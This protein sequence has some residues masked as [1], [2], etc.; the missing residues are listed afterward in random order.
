MGKRVYMELTIGVEMFFIQTMVWALCV[1]VQTKRQSWVR[2]GKYVNGIAHIVEWSKVSSTL[3]QV[4]ISGHK[5]TWCV[6]GGLEWPAT[7]GWTHR[8]CRWSGPWNIICSERRVLGGVWS[9]GALIPLDP[10]GMVIIFAISPY[11]VRQRASC[12][13]RDQRTQ[14]LHQQYLLGSRYQPSSECR[15]RRVFSLRYPNKS[16]RTRGRWCCYRWS[17]C[18]VCILAR[19]KR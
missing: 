17:C 3:Y 7:P 2:S 19:R 18:V 14:Q 8:S 5:R 12:S 1:S 13:E 6:L 16:S 4:D 11:S 15:I 9:V 10:P